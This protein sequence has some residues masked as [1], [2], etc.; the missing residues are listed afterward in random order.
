M[1]DR[2]PLQQFSISW[3]RSFIGARLKG[4]SYLY[5]PLTD[6]EAYEGDKGIDDQL[7]A[8]VIEFENQNRIVITWAMEDQFEGLAI[9]K[10]ETYTEIG[11]KI[12]DAGDRAGWH[13]FLDQNITAVGVSWQVSG[14]GCPESLWALRLSFLKGDVVIALGSNNNS[15]LNYMPD[16]LLV[17]F[18]PALAKGYHPKHTKEAAWGALL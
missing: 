4:I 12:I 9:F 6:K 11:N 15:D 18:D 16:E 8:V 5:V 1:S 13:K 10:D 2:M 17:I 3:L 14:E 7:T